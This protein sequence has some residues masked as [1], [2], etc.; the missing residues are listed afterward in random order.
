MNI[1]VVDN[2]LDP[3]FCDH[4]SYYILHC[5][6]HYLDNYSD[7]ANA[8]KDTLPF[9]H[10]EFGIDNFHIRYICRKLS[11][12]VLKEECTFI[13]AY[14]NI[15]HKGMDGSFHRDDGDFTVSYMVTPSLKD[16]GHFEYIDNGEVKKIDFVQN[17]IIIFEGK[18]LDHRGMAPKTMHP[19]ATLALKVKLG[20][21]IGSLSQGK[22]TLPNEK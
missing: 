8:N 18:N 20:T 1:E 14:A 12:E 21:P 11:R 17:R 5:M 3:E 13:R 16:S 7:K 22:V 2:W 4:L 15:Q 19:R 9:Y 10:A 6:P